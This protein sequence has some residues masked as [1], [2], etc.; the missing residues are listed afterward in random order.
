VVV[1][2]CVWELAAKSNHK[3]QALLALLFVKRTKL[4]IDKEYEYCKRLLRKLESIRHSC[5]G[6]IIHLLNSIL[7]SHAIIDYK[8]PVNAEDAPKEDKL[9]A[10]LSVV[11]DVLITEDK[12]LREW[13]QRKK[14]KTKVLTID[15]AL[16]T[17]TKG[18]SY[19]PSSS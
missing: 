9:I 8:E 14:L 18:H 1:D 11:A 2:E 15:E 19:T 12:K 5:A 17:L 16:L 6:S 10:A 7:R 3:A 13:F 4:V